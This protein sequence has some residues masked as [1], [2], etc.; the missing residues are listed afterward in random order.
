MES[1]YGSLLM[2][3]VCA[4]AT[5]LKGLAYPVNGIIMGGLD[6]NFTMAGECV[7]LLMKD[8]TTC[9]ATNTCYILCPDSDVAIES[10]MCRYDSILVNEQQCDAGKDLVGLSGVYGHAGS[11]RCNAIPKQDWGLEDFASA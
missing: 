2:Y 7:F 11:H 5:V 9:Y 3:A 1:Q 6:W 8:D 10:R 4:Y